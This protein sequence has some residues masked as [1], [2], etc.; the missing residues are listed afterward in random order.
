MPWSHDWWGITDRITD[1]RNCLFRSSA[2]CQANTTVRT[3]SGVVTD[4]GTVLQMRLEL[5]VGVQE[6]NRSPRGF[7]T[8]IGVNSTEPVE[9]TTHMDGTGM[10]FSDQSDRDESGNQKPTPVWVSIL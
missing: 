6:K 2:G 7:P 8:E 9:V 1:R 3:Y 10:S 5:S 4:T